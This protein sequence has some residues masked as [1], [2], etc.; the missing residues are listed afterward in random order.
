F[1]ANHPVSVL[2]DVRGNDKYL[3]DEILSRQALGGQ[4]ERW[5]KRVTPRFGA[6]ILG[7]G[8]LADLQGDDLYRSFRQSQGRGDFGLGVLWD[9]S[10]NDEYDCFV[11]CQASAEFG[12][13]L[14]L[15]GGGR[16]RFKIFQQ[17]QGFGGPKGSGVLVKAGMEDDSYSANDTQID[18]PSLADKKRNTSLVQ[19][20][21]M[22][23]RE[24]YS[25]GYSLAGGF[26]AL[27]D[28][29]GANEFSAGF[30]A[31]GSAY[32][33]GV[34]LLSVGIGQDTYHAAKYAQGAAAHFGVGIL[35]DSGG[36][37]KYQLDQQLGLGHGHD[38]G[39]GFLLDDGGNDQYVASSF[40]LGCASDQGIGIFWDRQGNDRYSS[41]E[42][43]VMGCAAARVPLPNTRIGGR[44]IG[45]F[46]DTGGVNEFNFPRIK[47]TYSSQHWIFDPMHLPPEF[48]QR[49][50]ANL[51][52]VGAV[53]NRP[54]TDDPW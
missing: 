6:G 15:D 16:D 22:G 53:T 50:K 49:R 8:I 33:Y 37:D 26:G 48:P 46:L 42:Q 7:Y 25:D 41:T 20:A 9:G 3:A 23:F 21:A 24:D 32:W 39:V 2:I 4:G 11:Q 44:T 47:G 30:Y 31:Q 18:F 51:I 5:S 36:D 27:L 45:L 34:G 40:A 29:G 14:L 17:G 12:G 52:G 10:G 54:E 35:H 38:Y 19:G 1:D 43:E 28:E 13:G